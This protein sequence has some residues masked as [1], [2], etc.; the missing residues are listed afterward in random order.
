MCE[1][2]RSDGCAFVEKVSV[3]I[4]VTIMSDQPVPEPALEPTL[5]SVLA[6][7]ARDNRIG[8]VARLIDPVRTREHRELKR[9]YVYALLDPGGA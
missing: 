7:I 9:A 5:T 6:G 4:K 1:V 8:R 2:V 3:V